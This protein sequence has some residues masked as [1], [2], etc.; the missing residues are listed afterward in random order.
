MH[1]IARLAAL[2]LA[3]LV[4]SGCEPAN[5]PGPPAKAGGPTASL[6]AP[7]PGSAGSVDPASPAPWA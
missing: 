7:G 1:A 5:E 2:A 3:A 6:A 4:A